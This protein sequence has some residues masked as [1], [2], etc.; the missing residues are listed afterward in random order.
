MNRRK[1]QLEEAIQAQIDTII[2]REMRDPRVGMVTITRVDLSGDLQNATI[3]VSVLGEPE[4]E[5]ETLKALRGAKGFF[6][7]ELAQ[8]LHVRHVPQ[9]HFAPDIALDQAMRVYELLENLD[10]PPE[11]DEADEAGAPGESTQ[12]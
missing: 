7:R 3:F 2:R 10:L 9:L 8:R 5:K 4:E 12:S 6:R 1:H 11:Q